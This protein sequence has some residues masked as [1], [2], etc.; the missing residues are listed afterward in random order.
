[1]KFSRFLVLLIMYSLL[2]Y[3]IAEFVP[4]IKLPN[5]R[6]HNL[7][8]FLIGL[9]ISFPLWIF[10]ISR[11]SF[12]NTFEHE[13]THLL[14][15]LLFLKKPKKFIASDGE[16]GLIA[17]TGGGNFLIALAPYFFP[18]FTYLFL[19]FFALVKSQFFPHCYLLLG[20]LT[21]YHLFSTMAEFSLQQPD[22]WKTGTLFSILFLIPA[23]II[24]HLFILVFVLG[25]WTSLKNYVLSA[26][27]SLFQLIKGLLQH[28]KELSCHISLL[29]YVDFEKETHRITR[30]TT[31]N[32]F[33]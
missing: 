5:L 29:T 9:G 26:F 18:T 25:Y 7:R 15:A 24:T 3:Y 13:L 4:W 17:Y 21:G 27:I 32:R 31:S 30:F 16:G 2:A 11:L 10:F 8:M 12:F 6:H 19:P 22:I 23:F 1:M 20:F 33:Y 14:T 28:G